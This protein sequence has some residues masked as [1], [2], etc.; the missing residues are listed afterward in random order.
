MNI[1]HVRNVCEAALL[2]AGRN[3]TVSEMVELFDPPDRPTTD[4]T[5]EA[6]GL[7][8]EQYAGRG[9]ELTETASGYRIQV[10]REL[11]EPVSKLW[12]ERAAK[13]SRA[14][15][16][17]LS[18]IAY[19]QPLTRAEIE[20]VRGVA[21]NPNIIRTLFERNWIRVVG[22]RELPGRPELLGTTRDFLDYFGLKTLAQL[23]PLAELK[24]LEDL[25]PQLVLPEP[26]G[27][28]QAVAV[29]EQSAVTEENAVEVQADETPDAQ[30]ETDAV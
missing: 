19:R 1:E 18:L 6:L 4:E 29:A 7:L 5:R 12:P 25:N 13:Y 17:T 8:S 21:V 3:L 28:V 16:E 10:R 20:A 22:H 23:P 26:V 30:A 2:A 24:S 14:L 15:L 9:I 11:A 27:Q